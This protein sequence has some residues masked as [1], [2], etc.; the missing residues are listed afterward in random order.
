MN[1]K[2]IIG[3]MIGAVLLFAA[4]ANVVSAAP[5]FAAS[6]LVDEEAGTIDASGPNGDQDQVRDQLRSQDR[7][8][9]RDGS[10]GE[11][12]GTG[13]D[14]ANG[15]CEMNQVMLGQQVQQQSM[16]GNMHG[17]QAEEQHEHM[18]QVGP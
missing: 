11:C 6:T 16:C 3:A 10:C 7:D 2:M 13:S 17:E 8:R 9:L 15:T 18:V 4:V 14:G 12:P 5:G 1:K